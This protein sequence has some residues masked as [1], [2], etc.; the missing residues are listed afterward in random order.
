M[1]FAARTLRRRRPQPVLTPE[2]RA[3]R[4]LDAA[5]ALTDAVTAHERMADVVRGF[6]AERLSVPAPRQTT[7]EFLDAVSRESTLPPAQRT[8][9]CEFF[10]RCDLVKFAGVRPAPEERR[11]TAELA[12]QLLDVARG[13]STTPT[14]AAPRPGR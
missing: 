5:I 10:E 3:A 12:R 7:A 4:D 1:A 14:A 13:A 8:A 2:Q 6:F 11:R 9:L